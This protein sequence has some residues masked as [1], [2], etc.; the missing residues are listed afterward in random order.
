MIKLLRENATE[1]I[2]Q[3]DGCLVVV[4]TRPIYPG[5]EILGCYTQPRWA[6]D[7]NP[8]A[9]QCESQ[10]TS[11]KTSISCSSKSLD[12]TKSLMMA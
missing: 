7:H 3:S 5:G 1:N 9:I 4:A 2:T 12:A 11:T 6:K 10:K 8:S